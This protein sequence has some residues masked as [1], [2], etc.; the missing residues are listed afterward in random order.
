MPGIAEL[1]I[2]VVIGGDAV[3]VAP[4]ALRQRR[5]SIDDQKR[6]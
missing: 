1:V 6:P 2:I 5:R 4:R 3:P